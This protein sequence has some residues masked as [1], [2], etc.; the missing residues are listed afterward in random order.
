VAILDLD[1]A[2][3]PFALPEVWDALT[4][5]GEV[6]TGKI[7]IKG[8]KRAYKWDIKDGMGQQGALETY[9]GQTPTPF[10][11][12]FYIWTDAQYAKWLTF[13]K[14]FMYNG[15]KFRPNPVTIYHPMLDSINI[16]QVIVEDIGAVE[17]VS[18]D[19]MFS[20]TVSLRE[21]V[22]PLPVSPVTPDAASNGDPNDDR[23][24]PRVKKLQAANGAKQTRL[25]NMQ[26]GRNPQVL[27]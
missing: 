6:W 1:A 18:D 25:D 14:L 12:T 23:T 24:D 22:R 13:A 16:G 7:E 3:S 5:G 17:K 19:L 10:T 27:K 9:R 11:I 2:A 26:K 4:V 15:F 21:F 8:A 20:V